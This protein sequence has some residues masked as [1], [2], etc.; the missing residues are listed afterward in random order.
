MDPQAALDELLEAVEAREWDRVDELANGL[1]QW[2]TNQGF[3]P[4]TIGPE[5]LGRDWHRTVAEFVCYMAQARVRD[6]RKRRERRR[7]C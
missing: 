1:L 4:R 3:P 6:A 7:R 2:L 5:T